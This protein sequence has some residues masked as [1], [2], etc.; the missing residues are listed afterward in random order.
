MQHSIF[1]TLILDDDPLDGSRSLRKRK[2]S[3]EGLDVQSKTS[4]KRRKRLSSPD[5]RED[6]VSRI[7]PVAEIQ[8]NDEVSEVAKATAPKQKSRLY[9]SLTAR[10]FFYKLKILSL[11]SILT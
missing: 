3:S 9:G 4:S 11:M 6:I 1:N 5:S 10:N 2:A 7:S 8:P